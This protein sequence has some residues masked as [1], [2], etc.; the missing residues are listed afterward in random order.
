MGTAFFFIGE[1]TTGGGGSTTFFGVTRG[2]RG[3]VGL[4]WGCGV[5][6]DEVIGDARSDVD[7]DPCS[8]ANLL[9]RICEGELLLKRVEHNHDNS[10]SIHVQRH[11]VE[12]WESHSFYPSLYYKG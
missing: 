7:I 4:G 3:G 2:V 5:L 9:R 11:P 6:E 10:Q 1:G 12:C 8:L